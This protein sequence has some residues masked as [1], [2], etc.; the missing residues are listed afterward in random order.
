MESYKINI[1]GIILEVTY[2]VEPIDE[3][4]GIRSNNVEI[5]S[6]NHNGQDIY[7]LISSIIIGLIEDELIGVENE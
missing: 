6:I 1:D 2:T 7:D 5:Q 4:V 3:T